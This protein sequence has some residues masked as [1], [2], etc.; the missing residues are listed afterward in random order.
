MA[1]IYY[2]QQMNVN[3]HP[4]IAKRMFGNF[5]KCCKRK[6]TCSTC[7]A[8]LQYSSPILVAQYPSGVK[9]QGEE[10]RRCP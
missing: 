6:K 4:A 3:M 2:P 5:V 7:I 10:Q 8:L 1:T 9:R